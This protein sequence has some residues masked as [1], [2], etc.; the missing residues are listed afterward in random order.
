MTKASLL[1]KYSSVMPSLKNPLL[2]ALALFTACTSPAAKK[3]CE[4]ADSS[5]VE[6]RIQRGINISHWLSQNPDQGTQRDLL[7][8]EEDVAYLAGIGYDHLRL[9][10]DEEH[11]WTETGEKK[12]KG[13]QLL[14]SAIG[15]C[16]KNNLMVIV[17]LHI[18]R[19]HNFGQGL[20]ALWT[21]PGAQLRFIEMWMELSGE[22]KKYPRGTVAYELLNE[23]VAERSSDW[24]HLIK[25]TVEAIRLEEPSRMIVLGSNRWQST[26]TFHELEIPE[27]DRNII[28]SFHFY[29]PHIFTHYKAPWMK[30]AAFTGVVNY[31]GQAVTQEELQNYDADLQAEVEKYNGYFTKDSLLKQL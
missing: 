30:I 11:L 28:V 4:P 25:R 14:H 26:N 15:W 29:T 1:N 7:F 31:P 20:N 2:F 24:N 27:N 9:P 3:E 16:L 5:G 6:F 21:D 22:L 19:S 17:D 10:V 13:F 18:I 8:T 23:A 12:A